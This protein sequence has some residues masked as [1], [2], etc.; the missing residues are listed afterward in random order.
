MVLLFFAFQRSDE[1]WKGVANAHC[2]PRSL[3]IPLL[4]HQKTAAAAAASSQE[5]HT[6]RERE[7]ERREREEKREEKKGR[8]ADRPAGKKIENTEARSSP[9]PH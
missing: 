4:P 5:E 6:E 2:Y 9:P 3:S 7:R 8:S 1:K